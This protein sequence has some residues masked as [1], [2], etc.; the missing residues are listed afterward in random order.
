MDITLNFFLKNYKSVIRQG[1]CARRSNEK[2]CG[3]IHFSLD[4]CPYRPIKYANQ[5]T[6]DFLMISYYY[7]INFHLGFPSLRVSGLKYLLNS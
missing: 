7:A 1:F 6:V 4:S 2:I 5:L 3:N